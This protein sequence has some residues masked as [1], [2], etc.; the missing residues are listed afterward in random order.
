V[1]EAGNQVTWNHFFFV[2]ALSA[3]RFTHS[4]AGLEA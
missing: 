1:G 2:G 4:F 3:R